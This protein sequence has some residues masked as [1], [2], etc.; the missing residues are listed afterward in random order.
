M[1]HG[2]N[3]GGVAR[4]QGGA[5]NKGPT[6]ERRR[7]PN[8]EAAEEAEEEGTWFS[9]SGCGKPHARRFAISSTFRV[10]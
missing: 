8:A 9:N 7:R 4:R 1:N 2:Q 5:G 3:A 6:Q 10:L